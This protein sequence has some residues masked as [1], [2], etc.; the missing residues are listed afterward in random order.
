MDGSESANLKS[1]AEATTTT[2]TQRETD[3][4]KQFVSKSRSC[5]NDR[6]SLNKKVNK[7]KK[8]PRRTPHTTKGRMEG[9]RIK[10]GLYKYKLAG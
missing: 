5:Y 1:S 9:S 4:R 6:V 8:H 7:K 10:L 3:L 2:Q